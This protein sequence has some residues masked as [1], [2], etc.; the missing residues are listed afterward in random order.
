MGDPMRSKARRWA[1]VGSVIFS[2]LVPPM[3]MVLRVSVA[4]WS[5]RPRKL[6]RAW[7]LVLACVA[8][9]ML[10]CAER[11][12]GATGVSAAGGLL[13]GV[14]ERGEGLAQVPGE[15]GGEHAD[16]DMGADPVLR[17]SDGWGAGPGRR[18]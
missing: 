10:A 9:L 6:R 15:V 4:R 12:A 17:A 14:G 1:G 3:V 5:M 16:Q 7:P 18:P 8:A 13:V 2:K 11:R